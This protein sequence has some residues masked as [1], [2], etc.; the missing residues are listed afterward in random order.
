MTNI[1]MK[2]KQLTFIA[3]VV[4][5][6][7][8]LFIGFYKK[9]KSPSVQET[10]SHTSISREHAGTDEDGHLVR[11]HVVDVN[12]PLTTIAPQQYREVENIPKFPLYENA[13]ELNSLTWET[14]DDFDRVVRWYSLALE[15][16]GWESTSSVNDKKTD[17]ELII[18]MSRSSQKVELHV[19]Q[20]DTGLTTIQVKKSI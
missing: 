10:N 18:H 11:S 4:C 12:T 1:Q 7:V 6:V 5:V 20:N 3:L 13:Q 16:L 17:S 15:D 8:F 19:V 14:A 2:N 9:A